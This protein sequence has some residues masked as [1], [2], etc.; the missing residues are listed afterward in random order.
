M[1]R[2]QEYFD[3]LLEHYGRPAARR[4]PSRLEALVSAVLSPRSAPKKVAEA[5]GYLK[6]YGL[7]ELRKLHELDLG[8]LALALR[9]AGNGAAKALKLKTLVAWIVD[10]HGGDLEKLA[11]L[12]RERL[13]EQLLEIK[14]IGPET[15]DA[16]LLHGLGIPSFIVDLAAH[17][18]AVRH[19]LALEDAGYDD[20]R[21]LY[22]KGLP[23]DPQ[24]YEAFHA[25]IGAVAKEH[26]RTKAV[27]EGCPLAPFLPSG[28]PLRA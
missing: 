13:R 19:E 15:A 6:T 28:S 3:A 27:C 14:G 5:L 11:G 10:R 26:C 8:T 22:E 7:L 12:P 2:L 16:V 9:P 18:V 21:E 24:L 25:L 17:R 23:R 1:P 20:L 4:F